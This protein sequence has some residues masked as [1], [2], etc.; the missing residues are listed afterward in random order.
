MDKNEKMLYNV[1]T[2]YIPKY[3]RHRG[4]DGLLEKGFP[5]IK[6]NYSPSTTER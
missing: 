4:W 1:D 2:I 3:K 5:A 6:T